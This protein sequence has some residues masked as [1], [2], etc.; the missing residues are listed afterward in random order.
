M[1]RWADISVSLDR[2]W[3]VIVRS[4]V[5]IGDKVKVHGTVT[6]EVTRGR[7]RKPCV[8]RNAKLCGCHRC[9]PPVLLIVIEEAS[10]EPCHQDVRETILIP[11]EHTNPMTVERGGFDTGRNGRI[12]EPPLSVVPDERGG[13]ADRLAV[14]IKC[15]PAEGKEVVVS[16][17]VVVKHCHPRSQ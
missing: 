11:I 12:C 16:V 3:R 13:E 2:A 7:T 17:L 6:V 1:G 5:N 4:P 15:A 8:S 10:P 14:R 9:E